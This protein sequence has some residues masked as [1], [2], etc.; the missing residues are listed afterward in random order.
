MTGVRFGRLIV[1]VYG[2]RGELEHVRVVMEK[3]LDI[4]GENN[5]SIIIYTDGHT[6]SCN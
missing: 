5:G 6:I 4:E 2:V 1:I 3:L